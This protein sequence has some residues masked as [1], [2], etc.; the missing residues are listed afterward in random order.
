MV[1]GPQSSSSV[2][3]CPNIEYGQL[4]RALFG[5]PL[6][7]TVLLIAGAIAIVS[8]VGA[9]VILHL[10]ASV[11]VHAG[12]A[13]IPAQQQPAN[14]PVPPQRRRTRMKSRFA[15]RVA[16]WFGAILLIVATA[17]AVKPPTNE[18]IQYVHNTKFVGSVRR[19]GYIVPIA[20]DLDNDE[21]DATTMF[22]GGEIVHNNGT[23]AAMSNC[24][25]VYRQEILLGLYDKIKSADSSAIREAIEAI[26]KEIEVRS[27]E[28]LDLMIMT[29][30]PDAFGGIIKES[31]L[32]SANVYDIPMHPVQHSEYRR[33]R[34]GSV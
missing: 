16:V 33:A 28:T 20:Y 30:G 7:I 14:Q 27:R 19:D 34:E 8:V 18:E 4:L 6:Q 17:G 11:L 23:E 3:V 2:W 5:S 10:T 22:S 1:V 31:D 9:L 26:H 25:E 15:S 12:N 13:V 29:Y 24:D 21:N 32:W